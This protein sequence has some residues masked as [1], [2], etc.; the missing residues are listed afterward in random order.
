[1]HRMLLEVLYNSAANKNTPKTQ[2]FKIIHKMA[3]RKI[4]SLFIKWIQNS[5][6]EKN[7]NTQS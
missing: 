3:G 4:A 6:F 1:M 2:I 5:F 7:K